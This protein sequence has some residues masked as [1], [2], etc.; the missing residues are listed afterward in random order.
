M[1]STKRKAPAVELQ[2]RVRARREA[3]E[4]LDTASSING[5][6]TSE[7]DSNVSSSSGSVEDE[8]ST[9]VLKIETLTN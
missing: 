7:E 2:R 6:E 9:L 8:V 5:D 4:E 3:S 1:S